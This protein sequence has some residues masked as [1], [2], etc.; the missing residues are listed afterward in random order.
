ME[1]RFQLAGWLVFL[2]CSA[3]FIVQNIR[4]GD[5]WGVAASVTFLVGC[6]VFLFPYIVGGKG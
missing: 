4:T 2:A 5:L 6:L 1:A 3:L